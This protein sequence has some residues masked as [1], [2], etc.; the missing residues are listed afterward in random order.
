MEDAATPASRLTERLLVEIL[1]Q[2]HRYAPG[3]EPDR[4][5]RVDRG[6]KRTRRLVAAGRDRTRDLVERTAALAGFTR[7]HFEP[8]V[9]G[10]RLNAV[11]ELADGFAATYELLADEPSRQALVNLL[12][13]RVLGPYHAPLPVTPMLFR[14]KQAHA[15][16]DLRL[17]PRTFDV[18]DPWFTPL[19]LYRVPVEGG[20][21]VTLHSHSV[22]VASVFLL[23]QYSYLRAM[24]PVAVEPG[25]VVL[26]VGGCWGDTALYFASRVGPRGRVYTFEFDPESL[27]VMRANLELNPDL[28]SRIEVVERPL[29]ERSGDTM[30]FIG[31]GRMT[32]VVP[33][34]DAERVIDTLSLDD[35]VDQAGIGRVDFVKMD[36][37]GAEARVLAGA[38]NTLA[39]DAPK[40]AVAAYHEHDDLV[41]L[42][43]AIAAAVSG[44][45]YYLDTFSP[46]E[47]ETVL[48]AAASRT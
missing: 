18:S 48:F 11:L 45:R 40:L 17:E 10:A 7:R 23:N 6:P 13:L 38:R 9:A 33:P 21:A 12:K 3:R 41:Q 30:G 1:G 42:P 34:Q 25:D 20:P 4:P 35:F 24:P 26:D 27:D 14:G 44:Y 15:D 47:E 2:A 46:L 19:S 43:A 39:R 32:R 28:A 29:W 22:D 8:R 36:V 37:E 5:T 16:D 31:G